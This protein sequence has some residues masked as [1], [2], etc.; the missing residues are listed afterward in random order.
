MQNKRPVPQLQIYPTPQTS[1]P[2]LPT[3]S[4]VG[5]DTLPSGRDGAFQ[6]SLRAA[7]PS[8]R[9][10]AAPAPYPPVPKDDTC[11]PAPCHKP[12]PA[13]RFL[14]YIPAPT[15]QP[16][17]R[18]TPGS[19]GVPADP[20]PAPPPGAS[21][22]GVA[23]LLTRSRSAPPWLLLGGRAARRWPSPGSSSSLAPGLSGGPAAAPGPT[24]R[25]L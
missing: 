1:R 4:S 22:A 13:G 17:A 18:P 10:D 8:Q 23:Q 12:V 7:A 16:C 9:R 6:P 19:V 5:S 2:E 14:S 21:S 20:P 15:T 11:S 3:A 25:R 24:W